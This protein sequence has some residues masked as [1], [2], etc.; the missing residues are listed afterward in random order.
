MSPNLGQISD[1]NIWDYALKKDQMKEW[2]LCGL[3]EFN[4]NIVDWSMADWEVK[5]MKKI[6]IDLNDMCKAM[7][8][9]PLIIPEKLE[10]L[11][12]VH[13]C[14]QLG[15]RLFTITDESSRKTMVNIGNPFRKCKGMYNRSSLVKKRD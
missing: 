6:N 14:R 15:G 13:L 4:G 3:S 1:V 2:T 7:K 10:A 11:N 12:H 8:P 5:N 9:G